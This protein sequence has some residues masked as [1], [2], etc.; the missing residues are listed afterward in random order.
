M[1]DKKNACVYFMKERIK[2][3]ITNMLPVPFSEI[4]SGVYLIVGF[5][6]TMIQI[7]EIDLMMCYSYVLCFES[8]LKG[9]LKILDIG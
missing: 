8:Y 6:N 4:F 2:N 7:S 3:P 9:S 5:S 1:C